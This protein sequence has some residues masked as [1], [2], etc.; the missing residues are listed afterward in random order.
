MDH[1]DP[2]RLGF[3]IYLRL[4]MHQFQKYHLL[5]ILQGMDYLIFGKK[6]PKSRSNK[7]YMNLLFDIVEPN[8]GTSYG[9]TGCGVFKGGIQ[10]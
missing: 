5:R 8:V 1:L 9:N 4:R 3:V 6:K 2:K 10:N 7:L